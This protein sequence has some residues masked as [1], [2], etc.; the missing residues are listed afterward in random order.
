MYK[1]NLA[2]NNL[3][4]SIWYKTK[5]NQ[6]KPNLTKYFAILFDNWH[7]FVLMMIST[8]SFVEILKFWTASLI[9]ICG[10]VIL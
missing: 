3:K 1:I 4:W 10:M 8:K 6:T 9:I 5:P 2:L 7:L